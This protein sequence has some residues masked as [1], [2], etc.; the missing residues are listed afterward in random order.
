MAESSVQ[1]LT[2]RTPQGRSTNA[3][4]LDVVAKAT[5]PFVQ[6]GKQGQDVLAALS[7]INPAI[8]AYTTAQEA[9][10]PDNIVQAKADNVTNWQLKN[11]MDMAGMNMENDNQFFNPPNSIL[12]N[13]AG[14]SDAYYQA[15]GQARA[16]DWHEQWDAIKAKN[17]NWKDSLDQQGDY[18][19]AWKDHYQDQFGAVAN[20]PQIMAA[21]APLLHAVKAKSDAE[22][23][24]GVNTKMQGDYLS[25]LQK[26]W[27]S[28]LKTGLN[29]VNFDPAAYKKMYDSE[30]ATQI[31]G[32]GTG[33]VVGRTEFNTAIIENT[34]RV[35]REIMGDPT[36][37]ASAALVKAT[38]ALSILKQVGTDSAGKPDVALAD[39]RGADGKASF[40]ELLNSGEETVHSLY[41]AR[42]TQDAQELVIQH[43]AI[44]DKGYQ[45]IVQDGTKPMSQAR[46]EINALAIPSDKKQIMLGHA[47]AYRN[48]DEGIDANNTKQVSLRYAIET[49]TTIPQLKQLQTAAR[50][51]MGDYI[52]HKDVDPIMQRATSRIDE[53]KAEANRAKTL[54]VSEKAL[55]V[56]YLAQGKSDIERIYAP[57][58][59]DANGGR[60]LALIKAMNRDS[61]AVLGVF[62]A[63]GGIKEISAAAAKA[64]DAATAGFIKDTDSMKPRPTLKEFTPQQ[65]SDQVAKGTLPADVFHEELQARI[66]AETARQKKLTETKG[67]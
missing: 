53:I 66:Y 60:K 58:I 44:M 3:P 48:E 29:A 62:S 21:A 22:F 43:E 45:E 12:N 26:G 7:S 35:A 51:A 16:G 2:S 31:K 23:A 8:A 41:A 47:L 42:H 30:F 56:Q 49:A 24:I 36:L 14:Y 6:Q 39:V 52:G 50:N 46:A 34:N 59:T 10:K 32:N 37:S 57:L 9:N 20:N 67:K 54:E 1:R 15:D 4:T 33:V 64:T 5:D 65:L 25:N 40:R 13:G 27:T 17:N 38:K 63:G 19:K 11:S 18:T 28:D 55:K 61:N